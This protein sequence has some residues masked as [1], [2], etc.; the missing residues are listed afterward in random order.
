MVNQPGGRP[1]GAVLLVFDKKKMEMKNG[2]QAAALARPKAFTLIELL[3]VIAI[4]AILAAMLLPALSKAKDKAKRTQ[5]LN[6]E[7]QLLLS[8]LGYAYDNNDKFPVGTTGFWIW[9]LPTASAD[10]MLSANA[11]FQKS[12]YCPTTAPRFTD[13]DNL[14][15]WNLGGSF[16]VLG[17]ASTLDG[18]A[19][20]IKTNANPSVHPTAVQYGPVLVNPGP[21][22]ERVLVADALISRVSEHDPAQKYS[23]S[24]HYDDIDTGSYGKHHLSAHLQ[25]GRTPA[26]GNL[27]ML[28]GHVEWRKFQKMTVRGYGGVGG[29]QDNGTCPTFWW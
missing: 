22:T 15:L 14:N 12:A 6:N 11:M 1:E 8:Y 18:T 26:G 23:G 21:I 9:D 29:S 20:L 10:A 7:K 25:G 16:R 4:I 28:D 17:Y 5:C 3:V 24:Y 13:Q 19:A 2:D 27:G